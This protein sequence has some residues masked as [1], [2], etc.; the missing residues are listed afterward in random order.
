MLSQMEKDA[1]GEKVLQ[2][3]NIKMQVS[4]QVFA[5]LSVKL[6]KHTYARNWFSSKKVVRNEIATNSQGDIQY[7]WAKVCCCQ[8]EKIL[9]QPLQCTASLPLCLPH[10]SLALVGPLYEQP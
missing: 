3:L 10:G 9:L 8:K 7:L 2:T 4:W 1:F 6:F 5:V